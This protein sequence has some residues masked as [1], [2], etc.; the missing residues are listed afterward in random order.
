MSSFLLKSE[1][2]QERWATV[3]RAKSHEVTGVVAVEMMSEVIKVFAKRL[4]THRRQEG[5]LEVP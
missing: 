3:V 5:A 4:Q 2:L 1:L